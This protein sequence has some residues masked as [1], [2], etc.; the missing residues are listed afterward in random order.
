MRFQ[1]LVL[2]LV[3]LFASAAINQADFVDFNDPHVIEVATFAVTEYNNQHTE[4]KLVFEKV[5]SGVSNVV[6]NGTR[7]SL[8]LSA[9]NHSSSNNYDTI[10]LEKS[11]KNFS[12]IAFAPIPHA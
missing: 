12:L 11:S 6:D 8:T 5:I 9:N 2:I 3:V 7:Y 10:V 4:A 1:S